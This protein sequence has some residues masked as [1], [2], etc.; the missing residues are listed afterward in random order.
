MCYTHGGVM[1]G[2][3]TSAYYFPDSGITMTLSA[4]IGG[5]IWCDLAYLLRK[6][7]IEVL[8]KE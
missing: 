5:Q 7:I 8:F 4:N 6:E 2:S 3:N 1:L